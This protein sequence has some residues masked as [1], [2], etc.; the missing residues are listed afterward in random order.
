[1]TGRELES[2]LNYIGMSKNVRK[3]AVKDHPEMIE[4]IACMSDL[5]VCDL[6]AKDYDL[7]YAESEELGLVKHEDKENYL[8]LVHRIKR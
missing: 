4:K 8:K 7:V 3:L 1:M 6:L 5:E 2:N